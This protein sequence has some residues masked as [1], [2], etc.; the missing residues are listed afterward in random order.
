MQQSVTYCIIVLTYLN[1]LKFYSC[2]E[3]W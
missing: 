1:Y 3:L 2:V